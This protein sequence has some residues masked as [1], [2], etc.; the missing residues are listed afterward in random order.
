[1]VCNPNIHLLFCVPS[2]FVTIILLCRP[3]NFA[4]STEAELHAE[5]EKIRIELLRL[6]A[7][8][9]KAKEE[10]EAKRK[11]AFQ[12]AEART[13]R[14]EEQRKQVAEEDAKRK[15]EAEEAETKVKQALQDE[16]QAKGEKSLVEV[17]EV[18]NAMEGKERAQM[19]KA[20]EEGKED[21][22]FLELAK[23]ETELVEG[24]ID[25]LESEYQVEGTKALGEDKEDNVCEES[26]GGEKEMEVDDEE[27]EALEAEDKVKGVI[28]LSKKEE[29]CNDREE[30]IPTKIQEANTVEYFDTIQEPLEKDIQSQ[31]DALE[32][33][34]IISSVDEVTTVN[35]TQQ[36]TN[37][38]LQESPIIAC[39]AQSIY[40]A[41]A[42]NVRTDSQATENAFVDEIVEA[43]LVQ[44]NEE[45]L[46]QKESS[47]TL[48]AQ[49]FDED[50]SSLNKNDP[51]TSLESPDSEAE[52]NAK[53]DGECKFIEPPIDTV[54]NVTGEGELRI[55]KRD[56][57]QKN[58]EN[59]ENEALAL[60]ATDNLNDLLAVQSTEDLN[61]TG[62]E[63]SVQS[64]TCPSRSEANEQN[65]QQKGAEYAQNNSLSTFDLSHETKVTMREENVEADDISETKEEAISQIAPIPVL[66]SS[67]PTNDTTDSYGVNAQSPTDDGDLIIM[68]NV[69]S[70]EIRTEDSDLSG[71]MEFTAVIAGNGLSS[72]KN[73]VTT[74]DPDNFNQNPENDELMGD[75]NA[76]IPLNFTQNLEIV[77]DERNDNALIE[78]S[79]AVSL[80]SEE[81]KSRI[82]TDNI[83]GVLEDIKPYDTSLNYTNAPIEM[84]V[85]DQ[86]LT[87]QDAPPSSPSKT[88]IGIKLEAV[89]YSTVDSISA[90][91]MSPS[92]S[93]GGS[94]ER[95]HSAGKSNPIP[96]YAKFRTISR[97]SYDRAYYTNTKEKTDESR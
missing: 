3:P 90:G 81:R 58:V 71:H 29:T 26:G 45:I 88:P 96:H 17:A 78:D 70:N 16:E 91:G 84:G 11:K 21:I 56:D 41:E 14:E 67:S 28:S 42:E 15:R 33:V 62:E 47:E 25:T 92:S 12:E 46:K 57:I 65:P 48:L 1:M 73:K 22:Q 49:H 6:E 37:S 32:S 63:V 52:G 74:M 77:E 18:T 44:T 35:T 54:G 7:I 24:R 23:H 10:E 93:M 40:S 43:I 30:E 38:S 8:Q 86:E 31:E 36:I 79:L 89:S 75:N 50:G 64:Q 59:N 83:E 4:A 85:A 76:G 82:T 2:C 13:K 72:L 60:P 94:P 61:A 95:M 55:A 66:N 69:K 87:L 27:I 97:N 80:D 68:E 51:D 20:L 9:R 39:D 53:L 34:G 19:E 5:E